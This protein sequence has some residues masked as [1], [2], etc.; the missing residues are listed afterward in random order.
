MND[1]AICGLTLVNKAGIELVMGAVLI[2]AT[3]AAGARFEKG[4]ISMAPCSQ[5]A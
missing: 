2:D 3:A 5:G 4:R 1:D